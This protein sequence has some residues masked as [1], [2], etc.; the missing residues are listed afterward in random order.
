MNNHAKST[1]APALLQLMSLAA[2]A[3]AQPPQL[4]ESIVG[5]TEETETETPP[6]PI[7]EPVATESDTPQ[8]TDEEVTP[9][10]VVPAVV[11][12]Q[13]DAILNGKYKQA[14]WIDVDGPIFGRFHWYLNHRLDMARDMGADLVIVRLT[15]PGGDL[16]QSLELA[17]RL[18]DIDWASTI[19]FV[20]TE[21]IS[22][23]AIIA[24]GA[25]RIYMQEGA[26]I[27]DA[28]PIRMGMDGA[29]RHAEE[30]IVSYLASAVREIAIAKNRPAAVA[31]AMADRSL[32]LY[33]AKER[34]TGRE[35][36]LKEDETQMADVAEQYDIGPK[37]PE[38]G[39]NR[40]LTLGARR[41]MDLH[42]CEGV[43]ASAEDM[44]ASLNVNDVKTTRMT[45]VDRT[46]YIL[47]RPWLTAL[48]LIAGLVG[49]YLELAA[50]GLSVAG[51][52]SATCFTIFFWSHALGGTSG[53]LEFMLFVLGILCLVCE[54]FVLPGFGVFGITGIVLVV[55]SLVMA[56]QDFL[57]PDSATEWSQLK[58][59]SLIVLGCVLG[60]SLLLLG[61]I[62]LLDSLPGLNRFRLSAPDSVDPSYT[63]GATSIAAANPAQQS[64]LQYGDCGVAE[65][66]L[67]PSGKVLF[68][69]RLIDVV[70]EG[71]YVDAGSSVSIVRIE[72]NRIV[73][74][75]NR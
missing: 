15:S 4:P 53:W 9:D 59:N 49:L 56:S 37:V 6:R 46:V 13:P 16:E 32:T 24:L 5:E 22:G 68:E 42:L 19:V 23:G 47:N 64:T 21:A 1:A 60:V 27:G 25:D 8:E 73:V 43:F 30:K 74:R 57:I 41:A 28:G 72:G 18:R 38:T 58:T 65:S 62:L 7:P 12:A 31:E 50:P 39:Q 61:Q 35:T 67:R 51:L 70:T 26:L 54:L 69:Q 55:A 10:K 71:D 33:M 45:W 63:Y 3:H 52:T 14:L 11:P 66:D 29:F 40:F 17:R 44:L 2:I 75:K 20:P 34:A 48:L 36:V